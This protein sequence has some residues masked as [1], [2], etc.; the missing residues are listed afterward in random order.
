MAAI[1][2]QG[3]VTFSK[4]P[5]ILNQ[6]QLRQILA[7]LSGVTRRPKAREPETYRGERH[8]LRGY[9]ALLIVYYRTVG[10]QNGHEEEKIVYATSL[11]RDDQGTWI[12][13]YAEERITP[14]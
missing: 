7:S 12:T 8:K 13:P 1:A 3:G 5:P 6:E 10:W 2:E 9:L 14:I 11:L 4:P